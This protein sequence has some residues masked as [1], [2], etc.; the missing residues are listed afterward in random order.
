MNNNQPFQ[1]KRTQALYTRMGTISNL[2]W[3]ISDLY[4]RATLGREK[5]PVAEVRDEKQKLR[6]EMSRILNAIGELEGTIEDLQ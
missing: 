2:I 4:E 5:I 3:S 1:T 6:L